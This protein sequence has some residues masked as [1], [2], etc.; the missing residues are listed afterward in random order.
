MGVGL[1]LVSG[2]FSDGVTEGQVGG[3]GP[4][5]DGKAAGRRGGGF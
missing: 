5:D 4:G 2:C 3:G 1:L